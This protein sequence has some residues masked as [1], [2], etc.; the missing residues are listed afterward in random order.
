[1]HDI[2]RTQLESSEELA[3]FEA[4]SFGGQTLAW[5][6][7]SGS[8]GE[9]AEN[10]L[11]EALL[12]ITNEAELDQFLGDLVRSAASAVGQV[13]R[14]P[15]GQ[16]V[17]G[18]LKSAAKHALPL[19]GGALGGY[20]G[21]PL[22]AK[23]GSGLASAAGNALGLEAENLSEEELQYEGAKQFVRFAADTVQKAVSTPSNGNAP[24]VARNAATAA[25][26]RFLPSLVGP[27][28][29]AAA[30]PSGGASA[31]RSGRWVRRGS[32]IVIYGA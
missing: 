1:M 15:V 18:L 8:L 31:A 21:G 3:S 17:G 27:S 14:S 10:E 11:A 24:T 23:L 12:Q 5:P 30:L 26:K 19:A 32:R 28:Q 2:D 6:A 22:G 20:F 16:A 9:Q 4:Q 29:G 13:V 7:A 25:A